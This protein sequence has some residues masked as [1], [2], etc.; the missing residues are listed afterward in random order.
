MDFQNVSV[1]GLQ[2]AY[3]EDGPA[4]GPLALL[5]HGFP[6]SPR[7]WRHLMP[8][9]AAKGYHVIAPAQRGYGPTEVPE[10]G[11]YQLGQLG[12]DANAL[13]EAFGADGNAVIIGHDWGAMMTY[14]AINLE[15]DRWRRA[16][17]MNV[18]PLASAAG[19]FF[20]FDQLKRSW[21]MFFFQS[22][23]AEM[24]VP[25][26]DYAFIDGL[27]ADWSPGF[28]ATEDLTYIKAALSAE[29]STLAALS[30]YRAMFD[31]A[32]QS[33]E[34]A[35]AQ[36]ASAQTTTI[37][38]LYLHGRED[39][40]FGLSVIGDPLAHRAPGSRMEV[41]DQAGH[42][43]QLQQPAVVNKLIIDWLDEG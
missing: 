36:A 2:F 26:N 13:H 34:L 1:N 33:P 20:D 5:L 37:P 12:K 22:P 15:P 10:D 25:M 42:F 31:P 29:G 27:W 6:D 16:V 39:G 18:P 21:Y 40:C 38:T 17:A 43:L 30:Y 35:D 23:L 11:R 24:A 28:D 41:V 3:L 4:S 9:L 8:V 19:A 14:T 32:Y 7:T